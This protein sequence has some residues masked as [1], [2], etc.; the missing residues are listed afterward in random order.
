MHSSP[1]VYA[2]S[3][4]AAIVAAQ[5]VEARDDGVCKQVVSESYGAPV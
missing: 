1:W 2:L 4:L 3:A 5:E